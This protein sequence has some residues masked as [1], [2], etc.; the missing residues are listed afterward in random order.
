MALTPPFGY[1]EIVP[2]Q[3]TDRVLLP[4]GGTPAFCRRLNALALSYAE[5]A[6]AARDYP[7]VFAS[8]D[9][10]ASFV[11]VIVL[12]LAEGEN[13]FVNAS[14]DWDP[15]AY[16]PAYV[17]RY[18]FCI[19][20]VYRDGKPSGE[21]LVCVAKDY[22]DPGAVALFD[23]EGRPTAHWQA[24]ERLLADYE[25]DLDRTAAMCAELAP[26]ALL[27][28]FT[29]DVQEGARKTTRLAG[30]YR[31]DAMRLAA[32]AP[33]ALKALVASGAMS[34]IYAH[35]HSLAN[36][37]RLYAREQKQAAAGRSARER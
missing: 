24:I 27:V 3:K 31:V 21:R 17:R 8:A 35:L 1:G 16:L 26:L 5:F 18:P 6:A 2:L 37:A 7:I 30:M 13:L 15:D 4:A 34:A 14:G 25:A 11:P 12:G 29:M 10:G 28:P 19:S 36:F 23:A 9:A 22:L 33:Q 20:K 32:L